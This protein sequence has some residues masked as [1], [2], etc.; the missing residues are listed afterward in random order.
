MGVVSSKKP[1]WTNIGRSIC[2][3]NVWLT[4][5]PT[6]QTSIKIDMEEPGIFKLDLP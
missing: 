6:G 3:I 4:L 5:N 2:V 1:P